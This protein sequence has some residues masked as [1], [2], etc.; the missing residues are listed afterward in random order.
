MKKLIILSLICVSYWGCEPFYSV[1]IANN[2]TFPIYIKTY[3]SIESLYPKE[4]VYYD[5]LLI[6]KT[7]TEN[8]YSVYR[9]SPGFHIQLYVAL[10]F[11][12]FPRDIPF[13]LIEIIK[14]ADTIVLDSKEKILNQID[15]ESKKRRY[16]IK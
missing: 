4:S 8:K 3:P 9:I 1:S 11:R 10:G 12:P 5:S 2:K 13:E 14:G 7:G 16:Y 6:L 15:L